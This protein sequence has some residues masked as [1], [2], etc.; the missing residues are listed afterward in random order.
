MAQPQMQQQGYP[1]QGYPQQGYPQQGYP[2]QPQ[3]G[4]PQ[5]GYPQQQMM[6]TDN[7]SPNGEFHKGLFDCFS[8]CGT[9]LLAWCCPCVVYGQNMQAAQQKEGCFADAAV[10]FCVAAL[11]C[12]SCLGA[13]GRDIVR[14]SRGIEGQFITDCLV[15]ACCVPCALTQE[16]AELVHAGKM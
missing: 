14:E 5:Q 15:H 2:Q 7:K 11:G 9:C 6:T 16:R 13:Y 3:Q 12:N 10:Y 1:Q 8:N 4:Y